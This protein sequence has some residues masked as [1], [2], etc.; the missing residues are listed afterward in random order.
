MHIGKYE[1]GVFYYNNCSVLSRTYVE[2]KVLAFKHFKQ[3][4]LLNPNSQINQNNLKIC[5]GD[6]YIENDQPRM[7]LKKNIDFIT[8]HLTRAPE[9]FKKAALFEQIFGI[10]SISTFILVVLVKLRVHL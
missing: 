10:L 8:K 2:R 7:T 5:V 6:I 4:L 3:A 9:E 1:V